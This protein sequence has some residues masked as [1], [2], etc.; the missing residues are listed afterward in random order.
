MLEV[1]TPV[2]FRGV[3]TDRPSVRGVVEVVIPG[4]GQGGVIIAYAY[5]VRLENGNY[6][7]ATPQQVRTRRT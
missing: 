7:V 3:H 4:P 5:G 1:G 2:W 6:K